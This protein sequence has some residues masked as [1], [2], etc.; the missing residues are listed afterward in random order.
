[1]T[2]EV[3][4]RAYRPGD[5]VGI[6]DCYNR[7]F[8]DAEHGIPARSAAH[9]EWK[10]GANPTGRVQH[11]VAEHRDQGIIGGYAG[12][13][14]AIWSEGREQLAAQ[15]VDLM[16]L[17]AWRRYGPRPGLFVH[18]GWKFHELYCG[19]DDGKVLFT[20]GWP[21]PAWRMGQR[22]LGYI[23]IRD[24]NLWFRE[25]APGAAPRPVSDEVAVRR[26]RRFTPEVDALF[27]ALRPTFG[28]ALVRDERYL[29]W[30][31]A[32]HPEVDYLL[33]ECRDRRSDRL[34]GIAVAVRC[35]FQR[36][37]T[38][39]LVDWLAP[40]DD[41]DATVAMVAEVERQAAADATGVVAMVWNPIDPRA[42][43][44]QQLGYHVRGTDYFLVLASFKYD[45]I[46]YRDQ[47]YFT[48]GDSDLV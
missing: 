45:T 23:N 15:G 44:F 3:E 13:P 17:P 9:W 32:D 48:M 2:D 7:I 34:R 39:F 26:V 20:Y 37:N 36:P 22:Y 24:W 18:I 5:E 47:W 12:I 46:Y 35:D 10:F 25:L 43:V 19:A 8:P 14:V 1:M 27:E 4:L 28:L 38:T 11:V 40:A 31:Y 42:L 30:R 41:R 6:L 16:V 29:N 21:V 33:L